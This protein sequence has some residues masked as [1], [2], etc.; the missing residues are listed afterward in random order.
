V[1]GEKLDQGSNMAVG[2]MVV[3]FDV[4]LMRWRIEGSE[5]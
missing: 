1:F 2:V 3:G 4:S 5:E